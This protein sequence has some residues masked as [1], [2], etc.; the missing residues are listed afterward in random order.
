MPNTK[1]AGG[2]AQVVEHLPSRSEA[3]IS[4]NSTTKNK[5]P[6]ASSLFLGNISLLL[7]MNKIS[8]N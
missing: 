7:Y 8:I 4:N 3:L 5:I 2:G 6:R 1:R